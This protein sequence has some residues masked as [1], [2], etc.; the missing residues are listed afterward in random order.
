LVSYPRKGTA[1]SRPQLPSRFYRALA[2]SAVGR[3]VTAQGIDRLPD[4]LY[5]RA[6]GSRIGAGEL[7]VALSLDEYDRTLI[8]KDRDLG[9][10]A[11]SRTEP[12]FAR[13]LEAKRARFSPKLTEFDG[14]LGTVAKAH[15]EAL[16]DPNNGVSPSLLEDY[17]AC[18]HRVFVTSVLRV[19]VDEEPELTIRLNPGDRGTLLHKILER[20]MFE[21]PKKGEGRLHGSSEESRLLAI[22]EEEFELCRERGQ[23]GYPAMWAADRLELIE[24]LKAW[25]IN[26]RCDELASGLS[27]GAYEVRFGWGREDSGSDN[28]VSTDEPVEISAGSATVS[29]SGRIDRLN[30]D[31]DRTQFRVVDYKT[32]STWGNPKDGALGGGQAVQLPL[33]M[34]AAAR[35]LR[36]E[37]EQGA[38]EY[39]YSTRRGGFKRGRFGGEEFTARS[40]DLALLLEEMLSGMRD[41]VYPMAVKGDR[42]CG[43]CVA[44][45]LC[46][47]D[48][49]RIIK[50]KAGDRARAGID[51]IREVE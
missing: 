35:V 46:P 33:Y 26:E 41:G 48:R 14:V 2:E 34:L 32:G 4:W 8:E 15:L 50:R 22:A 28:G 30:W 12:R 43:F 29:V 47:S 5:E 42:D 39:H 18:A 7:E 20:F 24:D 3:R 36:M 16:F 9:R 51:R 1:D 45:Q 38:A 31:P 44:N 21:E 23:T 37:P 13:A 17:A 6:S 11:L 27:E 49:M 10:A 40:A 25:L 19:R